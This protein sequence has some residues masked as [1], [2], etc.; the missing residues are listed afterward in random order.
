MAPNNPYEAIMQRC[1]C[2]YVDYIFT[3]LKEWGVNTNY[4]TICFLGGGGRIIQSFGNYGSNIHFCN[5]MK[6]NAKGYEF[7]ETTLAMKQR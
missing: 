5:D 4:T 2:K 1:L 3:R 6:I 7:F